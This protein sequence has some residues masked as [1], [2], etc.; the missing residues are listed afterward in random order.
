MTDDQHA[1]DDGAGE[2]P[3]L[4]DPE[5]PAVATAL[6]RTRADL[7]AY[8][9]R[10]PPMPVGLLADIDAALAAERGA[11]PAPSTVDAPGRGRRAGRRAVL[12]LVAAAAVV[13]A[14]VVGVLTA[15]APAGA[16]APSAL[17]I[18]PAPEVPVLAGG[19]GPSAL[20]AG[21]GRSDYGPLGDPGRLAGCLGA[22][23]VPA[24]ARP[25]GARQV[26]VDGRAGV[27]FVLPTGVAAR[28]RVLVVEPG[29]A[30]GAPLTLSD[31][32]VG[33]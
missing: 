8:G 20:R 13:A 25:V 26:V 7:A 1:A 28:F 31:T 11:A 32:L 21:L 18:T 12:L 4:P 22:H 27:L 29:C 16:P 30:A 23:G 3:D 14:I 19:D 5:D 15:V 2:P 10:T 9:E 17:P 24:G 6:A 33:R